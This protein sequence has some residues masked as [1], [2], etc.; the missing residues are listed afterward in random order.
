[1]K[2]YCRYCKD[3]TEHQKKDTRENVHM[4]NECDCNN[5]PISIV[6]EHD[7]LV[8]FGTMFEFVEWTDIGTLKQF[9]HDP[10]IGYSCIVDPQYFTYS[11]LT[12]AIT[13][14]VSDETNDNQRL[15]EFKT[16]NSSYKLY[17]AK[18]E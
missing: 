6:R 2:I 17:I 11:W 3:I 16:K 18:N 14:I 9:H 12:T 10:Q 15:I 4:C 1:M 8:N 13:E 5:M 7:G